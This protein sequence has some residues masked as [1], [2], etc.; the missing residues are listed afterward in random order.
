[1]SVAL[2]VGRRHFAVGSAEFLKAFFSTV[3]VRLEDEEWGTVYPIVMRDLYA[4]RLT[5]DRSQEALNELQRIRAGLAQ[6]KPTQVVWDFEDR[7]ARPPWGD[8]ISPDIKSMADY[9]LTSDGENL[10]D[11]LARALEE[12]QRVRK[13]VEVR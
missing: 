11:V 10:L 1:M 7:L 6:L 8:A 9:F 5:H 12:S 2:W 4:G 3:F 13:S